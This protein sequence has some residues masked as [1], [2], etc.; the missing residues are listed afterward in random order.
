MVTEVNLTGDSFNRRR[1]HTRTDVGIAAG[2]K[3]IRLLHNAA[4]K[5]RVIQSTKPTAFRLLLDLDNLPHPE[6][7][8]TP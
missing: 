4:A 1:V 6:P 5:Q 3:S 7:F 8:Q 2:A